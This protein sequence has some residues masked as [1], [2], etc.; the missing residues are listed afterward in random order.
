MTSLYLL[1]ALTANAVANILIKLGS[2]Q[3]AEGMRLLLTNPR[4]FFTNWFFFFGVLSF[5][6]ALVF[7]SLVLSRM[8]LSV[9]YPIMT[10]VGFMIVVG[11]SVLALREQL[12]WWQWIGIL[13]ILVGVV[14]LS[15]DSIRY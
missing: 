1:M 3:Y 8:Q 10:S 4:I 7:Y 11:F 15:Q 14:L 5:V 6:V 13:L 9:A 2:E 12:H